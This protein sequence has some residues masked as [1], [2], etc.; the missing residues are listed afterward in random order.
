M[1][2]RWPW[3]F[4]A[5]VIT[6][7]RVPAAQCRGTSEHWDTSTE[8]GYHKKTNPW[9]MEY[10]GNGSGGRYRGG[11]LTPRN[12]CLADGSPQRQAGPFDGEARRA[13]VAGVVAQPTRK[14]SKKAV[15]RAK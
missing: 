4:C 8:S 2:T 3:L 11:H 10:D 7:G 13:G 1:V 12:D 15:V 14:E 9:E 6:A 5:V